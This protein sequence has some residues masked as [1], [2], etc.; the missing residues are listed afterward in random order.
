ML[1]YSY[2]RPEN[3]DYHAQTHKKKEEGKKS[4]KNLND[5]SLSE[6]KETDKI[7]EGIP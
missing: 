5:H 7:L 1:V 3:M 4:Q 2:V 6:K